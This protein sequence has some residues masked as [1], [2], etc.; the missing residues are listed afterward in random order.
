MRFSILGLLGLVAFA[1]VGC[2]ALMKATYVWANV[3]YMST[4]FVLWL[5]VVAAI[6]TVGSTRAYLVGFTICGL[7][8]LYSDK[9]AADNYFTTYELATY[10]Y[11]LTP[12]AAKPGLSAQG[13]GITKA[14]NFRS[15]FDSLSSLAFGCLGGLVARYFYWLRQKQEAAAAASHSPGVVR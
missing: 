6:Y 9:L 7:A 10:L 2:A 4:F 13:G 12:E 5:A 8:Y 1:A 3:V 11:R 15:I 14:A